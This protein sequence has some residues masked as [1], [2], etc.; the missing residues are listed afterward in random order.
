M[1]YLTVLELKIGV[2]VMCVSR[3]TVISVLENNGFNFVPNKV[4]STHWKYSNETVDKKV[5]VIIRSKR[6][7]F[8]RILCHKISKQTNIPVEQ[9]FRFGGSKKHQ[10]GNGTAIGLFSNTEDFDYE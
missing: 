3:K 2:F 4:A 1:D 8:S 9:F 7:S 6:N 5:T 10:K